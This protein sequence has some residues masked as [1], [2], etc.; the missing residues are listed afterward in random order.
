[1]KQYKKAIPFLDVCLSAYRKKSDHGK[2]VIVLG[3]IA[4]AF[5]CLKN[6]R[7]SKKYY[8]ALIKLGEDRAGKEQYN[9]A[10]KRIK[11]LDI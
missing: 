8:K 1:M 10:V 5:F 6:Y 2:I 3:Q 7:E 11:E 9:I 4:D